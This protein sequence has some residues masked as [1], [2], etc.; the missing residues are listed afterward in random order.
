MQNGVVELSDE[1]IARLVQAGDRQAFGILFERYETKLRRYGKR[2]M[3]GSSDIEDA[4]QEV[5]I[6]TYVNIQ[7]FEVDK[8][9]ST[10]IYRIAHN[11]FI[12]F[13]KK[14]TRERISFFDF[15][16][17]LWHQIPDTSTTTED[18]LHR[19]EEKKLLEACL[20]SLKPKYREPLVLFYFEEKN[21]QEI[22]DIMHLPV[23]T[24]GIR[25]KR[26]RESIKKIIEQ[27]K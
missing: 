21:Y 1:E 17:L 8:K 20:D 22:A 9:F 15:D 4:V 27:K 16:T 13:L 10:W 2:F 11:T 5:F 14:K 12:N 26:G 3:G 24:V 18:I 23:A 6:K 7:S 19:K 25:L